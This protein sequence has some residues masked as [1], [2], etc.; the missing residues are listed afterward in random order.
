[1][2]RWTACSSDSPPSG[3]GGAAGAVLGVAATAAYAAAR[4]WP[5]VLPP[6]A[7]ASALVGAL[8]VGGVAGLYPAMR[9]SRLAPTEAISH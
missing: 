5:V 6:L 3:L 1:M 7:L 9:A 4:G 2:P 8:L